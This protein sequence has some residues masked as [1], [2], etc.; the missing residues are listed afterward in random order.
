MKSQVIQTSVNVLEPR[1]KKEN[2]IQLLLYK[3]EKP[4]LTFS[5]FKKKEIVNWYF[6]ICDIFWE[7]C[8]ICS[9]SNNNNIEFRRIKQETQLAK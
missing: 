2:E 5:T 7:C 4:N 6:V 3:S 9:I 1:K 8:N